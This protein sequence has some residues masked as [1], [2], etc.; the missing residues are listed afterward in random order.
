MYAP[1]GFKPTKI[2]VQPAEDAHPSINAL[3]A[4]Y[5]VAERERERGA[6]I[7][8]EKFRVNLY[9]TLIHCMFCSIVTFK[10]V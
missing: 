6:D 8:R 2:V 4:D 3:R 5:E 10:G 7:S 1:E 9:I